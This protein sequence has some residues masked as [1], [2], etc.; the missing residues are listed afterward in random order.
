[1]T[2]ARRVG[3]FSQTTGPWIR[4]IL[5]DDYQAALVR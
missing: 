4:A 2:E 5:R 1:M 3:R